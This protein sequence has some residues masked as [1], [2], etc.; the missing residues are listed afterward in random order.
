MM[1]LMFSRITEQVPTIQCMTTGAPT[2]MLILTPDKPEQSITIRITIAIP[3]TITIS[4]TIHITT[5]RTTHNRAERTITIG[6][7]FR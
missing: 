2:R 7:N 1:G 3:T 5:T 6:N 4:T